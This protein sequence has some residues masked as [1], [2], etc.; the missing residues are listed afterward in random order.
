MQ[1]E[2]IATQEALELLDIMIKITENP[3][4]VT[5]EELEVSWP[6]ETIVRCLE[7]IKDIVAAS[8]AFVGN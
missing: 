5:I 1:S 2:P 4:A 8:G 6:N 3:D 7:R